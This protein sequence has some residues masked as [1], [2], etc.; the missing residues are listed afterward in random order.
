MEKQDAV[1]Q[2]KY[3][4]VFERQVN[5]YSHVMDTFFAVTCE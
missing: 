2:N 4:R 5:V 1:I 3:G